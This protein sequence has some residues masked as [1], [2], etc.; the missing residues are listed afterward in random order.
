MGKKNE[1]S[2]IE[3]LIITCAGRGVKSKDAQKAIRAICRYFGG[4]MIYIPL[5]KEQGVSGENLRGIIADST[6][7]GIAQA[8]LEKIMMRYG[9][10]QLY[11][12]LE[13][14]AFRKIIAL[15]IFKEYG[16]AKGITMN[17]LAR[18][19]NI[20]FVHAYKLWREGQHETNE[21]SLPFL[22]FLELQE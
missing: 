5:K 19:Y 6:N 22:P 14:C 11:I 8:V 15:E 13:R 9:G 17:D 1:L 12:P 7:D 20:S 4:Q 21:R 3:D 2:I 10:L 18:R 16:S